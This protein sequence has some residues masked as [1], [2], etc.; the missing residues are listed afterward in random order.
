MI[1]K[2]LVAIAVSLVF[3][4]CSI[5]EN[6]SEKKAEPQWQMLFDGKTLN[7]WVQHGGK[8][9]F[10]VDPNEQAIV[11]TTVPNTHNSF[12]CTEKEY[13]DFV[14]ELDFMIDPNLNSGVQFRS[15]V[16][17]DP[18]LGEVVYGYQ[19]EIDPSP[20]SWTGGLYEESGR[21]WL[22]DL[23]DREFARKAFKPGQWNH[24]RLE[25]KDYMYRIW[26]NGVQAAE[27]ID[28]KSRK[29]FI[30]LQVH[31]VKNSNVRQVR[32]KNIKIQVFD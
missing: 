18:N 17:P 29:G 20:R 24:I 12:L 22:K 11:G 14:L 16:R 15:H 25:A 19:V 32:F 1:R 13:G 28:F 6:A 2:I 4:G 21:G 23:S 26:V 30:G 27:A 5:A 7:G 10:E 31:K 3:C 9:K 8:A